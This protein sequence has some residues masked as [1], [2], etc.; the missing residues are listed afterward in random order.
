MS[1]SS[2][3][4]NLPDPFVVFPQ[5]NRFPLTKTQHL[6]ASQIL[7]GTV[8]AIPA[9]ALTAPIVFNLS[10]D[11]TFTLPTNAQLFNVFG[12]ETDANGLVVAGGKVQLDDVFVVPLY[13]IGAAGD[14]VTITGAGATTLAGQVSGNLVLRCTAATVGSAPTFSK[15]LIL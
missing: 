13:S 11:V 6:S 2:I 1:F 7:D 9:S 3:G 8:T 12:G 10:A 15:T 14:V 4:V 5:P